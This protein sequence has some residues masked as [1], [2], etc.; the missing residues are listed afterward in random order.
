MAMRNKSER[1]TLVWISDEWRI[2]SHVAAQQFRLWITC[3]QKGMN[4]FDVLISA[5]TSK[6][7]Q[8]SK[9]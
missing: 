3:S 5:L 6:K 7:F 1:K 9:L 8:D 2:M 4:V